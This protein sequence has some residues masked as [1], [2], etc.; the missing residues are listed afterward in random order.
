M[1]NKYTVKKFNQMETFNGIAYNGFIL[2]NGQDVM[3]FENKGD[4]GETIFHFYNIDDDTEREKALFFELP[5]H[6]SYGD[7]DYENSK[8]ESRLE[9]LLEING[10]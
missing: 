3:S 10:L 6:P 1:A 5:C 4:G 7:S 8:L 2:R 9:Q